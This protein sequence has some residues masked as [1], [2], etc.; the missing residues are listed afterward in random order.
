[1]ESDDSSTAARHDATDAAV[2]RGSVRLVRPDD[3]RL[4]IDALVRAFL[5]DPVLRWCFPDDRRRG[6]QFD[7]LFQFLWAG[8]WSRH[9]LAYTTD[10]VSGVAVWLPP[11]QW[12][13]GPSEQ[14]RLLPRYLSDVGLRDFARVLRGFNLLESRHPHQAHFY[15]HFVGVMPERQGQGIGTTLLEPMLMRCDREG[16]PAY[17]EATT[18]RNRLFYQRNGFRVLDEVLYPKGPPTWLMWRDPRPRRTPDA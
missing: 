10:Q 12:R 13:V 15:L 1:M 7:G 4:A 14:L 18:A 3:R 16:T 8:L 9:H 6:R 17:L 5:D 11:D 2:E